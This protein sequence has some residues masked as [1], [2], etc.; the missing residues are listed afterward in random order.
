VLVLVALTAIVIVVTN[1]SRVGDPFS[2]VQLFVDPHSLAAQA[3]ASLER[4]DPA[5]AALV[6]KIA[7]QPAGIW[8]GSWVPIDR[9][10]ATVNTVMREAAARDAMPLFVLYALPYRVCGHK[11]TGGLTNASAYERWIGQVVVGIGSG[12]AAVILEPDAVAQVAQSG[13]L[14]PDGA[15][16]RLEVL[17]RAVDQLVRLP[18]TAVYLDA[19]LSR[20]R[21]AKVI[22]PLLLAAGIDKAAGFSLNVS[23]FSS[24]A[25]EE[26]Y[27]DKL[28]RLVSRAHF[29]IDTSRNG[30]ATAE[31]WCN[32]PGQALGVP[33]T[34]N[35]DNPRVD[36]LLWIK[37]PGASDGP[38]NGGPPA[39]TFW[40][41]YARNLAANARW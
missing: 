11:A 34:A 18:N 25:A 35:T 27:G 24:T 37:P 30:A 9:V 23:N 40:V 7:G 33:P 13:C 10:A 14:S 31:T 29:V 32:P 36:A 8:V 5:G 41:S 3:A 21:P 26:S 2:G 16:D 19:G 22:A 20:W 1:R 12:K 17:H 4:S 39:G 28:S 6:R 15:R 38:C